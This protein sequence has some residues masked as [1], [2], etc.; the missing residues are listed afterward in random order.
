MYFYCLGM[1]LVM[2]CKR[3]ELFEHNRKQIFI[4]GYKPQNAGYLEN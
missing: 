1:G 4:Q 3:A 2:F